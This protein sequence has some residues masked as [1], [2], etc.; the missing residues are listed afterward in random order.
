MTVLQKNLVFKLDKNQYELKFPNVGQYMDIENMRI[1]LTNGAY[2]EM[3]RTGL[4]SSYF[5]IDLVDAI[6]ILYVLVPNLRN[7]LNV[8][9]YNELDVFM[10]KKIEKAYKNE[11]KPWYDSLMDKLL[12][13]EEI[14]EEIQPKYEEVDQEVIDLN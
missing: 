12:A 5:N 3:L 6:S 2:T 10:A 13:D 1:G 8:T 7:D 14:P 4:K 11:I 9:N